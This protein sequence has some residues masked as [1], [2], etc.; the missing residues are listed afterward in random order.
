MSAFTG[1]DRA[2]FPPSMAQ[3]LPTDLGESKWN[4]IEA[5]KNCKLSTKLFLS[6]IE[7]S[8]KKLKL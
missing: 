4:S 7:E 6:Q 2:G 1:G 5:S 3:A 8:P